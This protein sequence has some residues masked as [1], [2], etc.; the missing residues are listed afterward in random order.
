MLDLNTRRHFTGT[1]T[2]YFILLTRVLLLLFY[3]ILSLHFTPGLQSAV[4][5]LL[6]LC[7]LPRSAVCSLHFT[8]T[9]VEHNC[10]P[11]SEN[12]LRRNPAGVRVTSGQR[13]SKLTKIINI[14]LQTSVG[15]F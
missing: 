1:K 10:N 12:E 11:A 4:C 15:L 2:P 13:P 9:V 7:I 8:L 5:I 14:V 3:F 6:S